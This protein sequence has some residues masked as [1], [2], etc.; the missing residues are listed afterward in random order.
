MSTKPKGSFIDSMLQVKSEAIWVFLGQFGV[1]VG[2]FGGIKLLT[3]FLSPDQF[4][5]IAVANTIIA[6]IGTNLFGPISQGILRFWSISC[7]RNEISAFLFAMKRLSRFL[8][9]LVWFFGFGLSVFLFVEEVR[10]WALLFLLALFVGAVTGWYSIRLSA[11]MASRKRSIV[12][13][14]NFG[15]ALL[16]PLMA[17]ILI[18]VLGAGPSV[19]MIG[20]LISVCVVAL[21]S[22]NLFKK[23][24]LSKT[25]SVAVSADSNNHAAGIEKEIIRFSMPFFF[26]SI[27]SWIHLSC[28]RWALQAFHGS[29][30]VGIF[31]VISQIAVYPLV[32]G[33][34]FLSNLF[35]PIAYEKAG[36]LKSNQSVISA[37]R[38]LFLMTGLYIIGAA[39]LILL[40]SFLHKPLVL[41]VSDE[42]Y[43]GISNLL[44]GLTL[45]WGL[46][47]LGQML[48]NFGMLANEPK[49]YMPPIAISGITAVVSTF[50]LSSK[51]GAWGVVWGIGISGC[52]YSFWCLL[53]AKRL[54]TKRFR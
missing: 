14:L 9:I 2:T 47:Y 8:F 19:V 24:V 34:S 39:A 11:L 45:A 23:V 15:A 35:V 51:F 43:C 48:S 27:F 50:Y 44:P 21:S 12:A 5:K 6:L 29:D 22:E 33:S 49:I 31:F 16:K 7:T 54:L 41:L 42:G 30:V 1:A 36:N 38:I 28:D 17:S 46:F 40:F 32:F 13:L 3:F 52:L 37:N 26:W 20:Y 10:N 4:G 53:I 25:G 18:M